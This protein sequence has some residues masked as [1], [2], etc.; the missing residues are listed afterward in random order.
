MQINLD[1]SCFLHND[2]DANLLRRITG[3]LPYRF[4]HINQGFKYLG[5]FIKPLG[6]L[7]KDWHWILTKFEKRIHHWTNRLLS[8]G[9]HLVLIKSVL[10]SLPV[11]WMA[12]VPIPQS[13]L[14]KLR[15]MIFSFLWGS[16]SKKKKYHLV[17]WHILACPTSLGGWAIKQLSWFSLSLRLKSLWLVINGKGIWYQPLSIK[18]MRRLPLHSWLCKKSF[19]FRVASVIWKGFLLTISWLSKGLTWKAGNGSSIR[20]GEDPYY[21][22][23][24]LWLGVPQQTA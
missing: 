10:S 13:I 6:Y 12:L 18:Y 7:V 2:L 1:K 11:Y 3:F 19:S 9:G 4:E 5:Y 21:G 8:L 22:E 20:L 15:R 24:F 17:D 23:K 16:S 14:E